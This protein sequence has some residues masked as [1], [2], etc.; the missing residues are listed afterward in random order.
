MRLLHITATHLNPVGGIPVVLRDLVNAQNKIIDFDSRVLSLKARVDQMDSDYFDYLDNNDFEK[1]IDNY[2]PDVVIFHSHYYVDYLKIYRTLIKRN[3]PYYIEPHGSFGKAALQKSKIK[4][5]IANTFLFRSLINHARGFIFLNENEKNDSQYRT[6]KDLIIPNGIKA[7]EINIVKT[8]NEP[9]FYFIGRYDFNHK[10]LDYLLKALAI[11]DRKK[12]SINVHFYGCGNPQEEREINETISLFNTLKVSNL[13]VIK[14]DEQI[15]ALSALGIMLLTSR[16]EGFPMSV[17]EAWNY[18]NPCIVTR[19]TNVSDEVVANNLG[20]MTQLDANSIANTILLAKDEYEK[21]KDQYIRH[22]RDYVRKKYDWD[23]IAR[24]SY[25][26]FKNE[27]NNGKS[28]NNA[29]N[30]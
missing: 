10:G 3:I 6:D 21:N 23:E 2:T 1:Y 29:F 25:E 14:K 8:R 11:L 22:T 12:V 27:V 5:A 24:I 16:Y 15:E 26:Q 13:G 19:G 9:V 20:W 4:K 30:I 28:N 7:D 17:L 18:G